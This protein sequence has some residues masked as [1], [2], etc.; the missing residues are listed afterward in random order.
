M[1]TLATASRYDKQFTRG[2]NYVSPIT[3]TTIRSISNS[4]ALHFSA[5]NNQKISFRP[6]LSFFCVVSSTFMRQNVEEIFH[7]CQRTIIIAFVIQIHIKK[8]ALW[9]KK[10]TSFGISGDYRRRVAEIEQVMNWAVQDIEEPQRSSRFICRCASM[11]QRR[12]ARLVCS[13]FSVQQWSGLS[14]NDDR[15]IRNSICSTNCFSA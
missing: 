11:G 2:K 14:A 7:A 1:L 15:W 6:F 12:K 9:L 4:R 10:A 13:G 8:I 5:R 3:A